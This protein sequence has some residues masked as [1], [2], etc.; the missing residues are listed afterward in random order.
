MD[1]DKGATPQTVQ[2]IQLDGLTGEYEGKPAFSS[3][4]LELV[5]HVKIKLGVSI[6]SCE[7]TLGELMGLKDGSVLKL[8]RY[9]GD[10]ADVYLDD[11]L[12]ARGELV[13][14]GD[15]FGVKITEIVPH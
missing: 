15:N 8:D 9:T 4:K 3:S 11:K 1:N 2:K 6:G 14:V 12:V 10:P 7:V 13:V 5:K